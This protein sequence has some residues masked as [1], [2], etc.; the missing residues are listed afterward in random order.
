MARDGSV[1][2]LL[3]NQAQRPAEHEE[4]YPEFMNPMKLIQDNSASIRVP[5]QISEHRKDHE[6]IV[7][8]DAGTG[9]AGPPSQTENRDTLEMVAAAQNEGQPSQDGKITIDSTGFQ[10][11]YRVSNAVDEENIQEEVRIQAQNLMDRLRVEPIQ[12]LQ[13]P[14]SRQPAVARSALGERHLFELPTSL[15]EDLYKE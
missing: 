1:L 8:V 14:G 7:R 2:V 10:E 12:Q 3:S 13:R 4:V 6:A 11:L 5:S 15:V 9:Q